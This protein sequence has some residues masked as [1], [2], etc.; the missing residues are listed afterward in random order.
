M[1]NQTEQNYL[2]VAALNIWVETSK[3]A[4]FSPQQELLLDKLTYA[5][6][7]AVVAHA[8]Q[9]GKSIPEDKGY[10]N[11]LI[12]EIHSLAKVKK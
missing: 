7:P 9:Q 5:L 12:S 3:L 10:R 1:L 11:W 6:A 4:R 2:L 8:K